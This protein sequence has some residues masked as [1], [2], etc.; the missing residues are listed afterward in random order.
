M[1]GGTGAP[2]FF[3]QPRPACP[4]FITLFFSGGPSVLSGTP[5]ADK[6]A[7]PINQATVACSV[8]RLDCDV[9]GL[10]YS[11]PDQLQVWLTWPLTWPMGSSRTHS[12]LEVNNTVLY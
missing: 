1:G 10:A 4:P 11:A 2:I 7:N 8:S 6:Q 9:F 5:A 3:S 12:A